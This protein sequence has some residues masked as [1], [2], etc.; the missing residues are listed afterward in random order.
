MI[1]TLLTTAGLMAA[2]TLAGCTGEG[3]STTASVTPAPEAVTTAVNDT[4]TAGTPAANLVTYTFDV[5]GMHCGGCADGLTQQIVKLPGVSECDISFDDSRAIVKAAAGTDEA[6]MAMIQQ[7]NYV[8]TPVVPTMQTWTFEVDGM[9]CGGCANTLSGLIA[10][11]PGVEAC[12][13]TFD[14]GRAVVQA[15]PDSADAVKAVIAGQGYGFKTVTEE[16]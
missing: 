12:D 4:T 11:V 6:V 3:T 15:M 7:A 13:V 9:H 1:R 14:D 2:V 5:Q 10:G 8:V 16:G